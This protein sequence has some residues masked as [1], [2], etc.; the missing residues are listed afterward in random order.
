MEEREKERQGR[1]NTVLHLDDLYLCHSL[2]GLFH[3]YHPSLIVFLGI[4]V[5]QLVI[6]YFS[7]TYSAHQSSK[8]F[9]SLTSMPSSFKTLVLN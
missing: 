3:A 2:S 7:L 1:P 4:L 6:L 9:F 8:L 5:Y